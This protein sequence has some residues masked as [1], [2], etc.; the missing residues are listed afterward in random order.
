M[1][2]I[3][4]TLAALCLA[5]TAWAGDH[6]VNGY[7][8][9]NGTYVAPHFQSNPNN[10]T[11]DNYSTRGNVNPYTGQAG[12]K[13]DTRPSHN[14]HATPAYS[15]PAYGAP[16]TQLHPWGAD[17]YGPSNGSDNAAGCRSFSGC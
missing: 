5:G 2:L 12:T 4:G 1:K 17:T 7:T 6:Y 8:R 9:S 11:S 16:K 13:L 3:L 10:T 14:G 15:Q